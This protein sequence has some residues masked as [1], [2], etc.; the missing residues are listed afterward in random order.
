MNPNL[1]AREAKNITD[2]ISSDIL[3]LTKILSLVMLNSEETERAYAISNANL[4]SAGVL[5]GMASVNIQRLLGRDPNHSVGGKLK[6][7]S[8]VGIPGE[9]P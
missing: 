2:Q 4:L 1:S 7:V 6:P 3:R 8:G 9:K 5:I